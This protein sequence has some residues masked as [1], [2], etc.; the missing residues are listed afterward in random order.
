MKN[1]SFKK[2]RSYVFQYMF[3]LFFTTIGFSQKNVNLI[4]GQVPINIEE[5]SRSGLQQ[6]SNS[7]STIALFKSIEGTYQ[8]Q[9]KDSEYK[10]MFSKFIY[11]LIQ[12]KRLKSEDVYLQLDK[13]STLYLP[14]LDK[15]KSINF[16]ELKSS[17]YKT[18]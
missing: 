2:K 3:F 9:I 16:K 17:I 13:K 14:S 6:S 7:T 5:M 4:Q 15:L 11:E 1:M 8:I 10:V 12:T 18:K